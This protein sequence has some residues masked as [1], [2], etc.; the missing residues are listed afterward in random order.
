[1]RLIKEIGRK[2]SLTHHI[3]MRSD[4]LNKV[5]RL[6]RTLASPLFMLVYSVIFAFGLLLLFNFAVNA[7]TGLR[8]IIQGGGGEL[9]S[10][11]FTFHFGDG[12]LMGTVYIA[13]TILLAALSAVRMYK[14]YISYHARDINKGTSGTA[15]WTT[16]KEIDEQFK[17]VPLHPSR[18]E[19]EKK[20]VN[21]YVGKPGNIIS[22]WRDYLYIDTQ[23]SNNLYLGT[24]RSGKGELYVFPLIDLCSR[25]K[26][27]K[28]RPSLVL[29]DPKLELY[30]SSKKTLEDRGYK[31]RLINLDDPIKSA[32]YDPLYIAVQYYKRGNEEKAQQAAKTF[33]FGVFNS[34]NDMQEP[35][36][37]NTATDLFTALI[38]ANITD[39]LEMDEVL[40]QRR[41]EALKLKKSNYRELKGDEES[42]RLA[43]ERWERLNEMIPEGEDAVSIDQI[44]CIPDYVEYRD[45]HPNERNINCYSV[46]NFFKELCDR[47]SIGSGQDKR[48]MEKKA[49]TL[50]DDYFNSRPSLDF[51][52]TLYTTVKSAGDRTKGSIFVNMQSALTIFSLQ[53]IAKMTAEN[54]IDFE[55]LGYGDS[56]VAVFLG[57]PSED[58]SNHFLATT[59]VAQLYQYLFQLTKSR[60]GRLYRNVRFILDEFGNMPVIENFAGF[61]TVCLGIGMSFDLFVQSY[62][63]IDVKYGDDAA[64]IK[65]NC[66]NHYYIL[67]NGNES[68]EEFSKMLGTKTEIEVQR[69]GTRFATNKTYMENSKEVRLINPGDLNVLKEGETVMYRGAK[70]TDML[71]AG[72]RSYPIIN[73]YLEGLSFMLTVRLFTEVFVKRL[74]LKSARRISDTGKTASFK[75]EYRLMKSLSQAYYGTALLYRYQYMTEDFPNP[76]DISFA[77]VCEESREHI[78][79]TARINDPE[80]VARRLKL[81]MMRGARSAGARALKELRYYAR[82]YNSM[83]DKF[84]EDF[85]EIFDLSA[86]LSVGDALSRLEH[87]ETEEF[88]GRFKTNMITLLR[89]E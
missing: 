12:G 88:S 54:D 26:D 5:M 34:G 2:V 27:I 63:Q 39:M 69:T 57:I 23:L 86:G 14:V 76:N 30:K 85:M 31:V 13:F 77:D 7:V 81:M 36:W 10:L 60:S 55:E 64:T 6:N 61:V 44:T 89:K 68:T 78:D 48:A 40:N 50:L 19:G 51:A 11:I 82:F 87:T 17:A 73:E 58:R 35:I 71:G 67:N 37:K 56:P 46:I 59:Y 53:N 1:M 62:N 3:P 9:K 65:E 45:I 32:G 25:A 80:D 21:Y 24:T 29:F 52:R 47:A 72:V 38:I 42:M 84:G 83:A 18:R 79:Y 49:E 16:V 74:F 22:R 20:E 15:R 4:N 43:V 33:A 28:D 41:R 66:A 70:R 75:Q 8:E